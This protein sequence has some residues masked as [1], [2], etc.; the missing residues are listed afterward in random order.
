MSIPVGKLG[1]HAPRTLSRVV[2]ESLSDA[3][4]GGRRRNIPF[5]GRYFLGPDKKDAR[6]ATGPIVITGAQRM[7]S[8]LPVHAGD[9]TPPIR[10]EI[11]FAD[12]VR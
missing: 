12:E 7:R 10:R 4:T 6:P 9:E 11:Q 8:E 2:S 1:F 5:I 3:P